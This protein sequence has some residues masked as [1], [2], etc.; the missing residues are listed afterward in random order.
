MVSTAQ[1]SSSSRTSP[2][3]A[4]QDSPFISVPEGSVGIV[5]SEII[6]FD[7]P[8]HLA[9]GQVLRQYQL[10][11]ES[12]GELNRDASNHVLVCHELHASHHVTCI[13]ANDPIYVCSCVN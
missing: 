10:A 5:E 13:D 1:S 4:S 3:T 12:Y 6:A 9:S 8:L 11:I 2:A 7:E